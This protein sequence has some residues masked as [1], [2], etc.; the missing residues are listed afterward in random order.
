MAESLRLCVSCIVQ[1]CEKV[2]L[3]LGACTGVSKAQSQSYKSAKI[4]R[5]KPKH[6]N[7]RDV[8]SA[9]NV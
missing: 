1:D 2:A 9:V 7:Y 4:R 3:H 6:S 5:K 8:I